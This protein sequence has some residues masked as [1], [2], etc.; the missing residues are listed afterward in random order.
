MAVPRMDYKCKKK[1]INS[2]IKSKTFILISISDQGAQ[3]LS[4]DRGNKNICVLEIN[5]GIL[6][7]YFT[8]L[9]LD[10]LDQFCYIGTNRGD[11]YEIDIKR[12]ICKR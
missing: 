4:I 2:S 11:F 3:I 7:V 1:S 8:S 9:A 6:E 5:F 12:A 10:S